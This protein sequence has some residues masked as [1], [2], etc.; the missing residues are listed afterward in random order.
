MIYRAALILSFFIGDSLL[1][2]NLK[3]SVMMHVTEYEVNKTVFMHRIDTI[4]GIRKEVWAVDGVQVPEHEYY[5]Q[6]AAQQAL[7]YKKQ[8]QEEHEKIR[9]QQD[10]ILQEQRAIYIKMVQHVLSIIEVY[11]NKLS[12]TR[13]ERYLTFHEDS[14]PTR[15]AFDAFLHTELVKAQDLL[16]DGVHAS[17]KEAQA[18]LESLQA[19]PERCKRLCQDTLQ[20]A[21]EHSDDTRLLKDLLHIVAEVGAVPTI[22]H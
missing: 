6:F 5:D 14:F 4:D 9:K 21:R 17:F 12:D 1:A 10:F 8:R 11:I 20:T 18:I 7:E 19:Y 16:R 15:E 22:K 3:R 2:V 13:L